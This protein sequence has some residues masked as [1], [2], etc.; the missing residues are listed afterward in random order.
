MITT[1]VTVSIEVCMKR[2]AITLSA[3]LLT[4]ILGVARGA[5]AQPGIT[6]PHPTMPWNQFGSPDYGQPIRYIEV[7]AQ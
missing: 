2:R 4:A 3:L 5:A 1:H 7:P 6:A